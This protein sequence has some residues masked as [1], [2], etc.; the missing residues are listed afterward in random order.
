MTDLLNEG[1]TFTPVR[2]V[3]TDDGDKY[4]DG[5]E[6]EQKTEKECPSC[7]GTIKTDQQHGIGIAWS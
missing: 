7:D 1:F 2:L 3:A 5:A 4:I 6:F